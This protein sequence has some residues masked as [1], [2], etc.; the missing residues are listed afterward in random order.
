M[1]KWHVQKQ[2]HRT[3]QTHAERQDAT[4]IQN[5]LLF[6]IFWIFLNLFIIYD[7]NDVSKKYWIIALVRSMIFIE[8][9]NKF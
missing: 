4:D 1:T 6:G 9:L 8:G 2:T 3:A 7:L 5:K